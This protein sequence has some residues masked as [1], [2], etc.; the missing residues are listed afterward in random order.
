MQFISG[1]TVFEEKRPATAFE[2]RVQEISRR[3]FSGDTHVT[4]EHRQE[5]LQQLERLMVSREHREEEAQQQQPVR[6]LNA[7]DIYSN[8]PEFAEPIVPV[9][10]KPAKIEV[11]QRSEEQVPIEPVV[12]NPP[13]NEEVPMDIEQP[14]EQNVI[15]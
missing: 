14:I 7:A 12:N 10:P 11:E 8:V 9:V 13:Q 3:I 15:Q 4:L 5:M 1:K 2:K 6:V